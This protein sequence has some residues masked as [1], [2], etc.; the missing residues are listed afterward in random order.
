MKS[1]LV[2]NVEWEKPTAHETCSYVDSSGYASVPIK[3]MLIYRCE[4]IETCLG[5]SD[6]YFQQGWLS[7]FNMNIFSQLKPTHARIQR[8]AAS[9]NISARQRNA[10]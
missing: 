10:I 7:I 4:S 8:R 2:T 1:I 3:E 9:I 6:T 5:T